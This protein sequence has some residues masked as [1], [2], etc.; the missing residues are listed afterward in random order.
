MCNILTPDNTFH[1]IF[2]DISYLL[3]PI[4]CVFCLN[5]LTWHTVVRI[6]I[7]LETDQLR[8]CVADADT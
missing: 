6:N 7:T 5:P 2:S 8:T 3:Q 4:K 1:N